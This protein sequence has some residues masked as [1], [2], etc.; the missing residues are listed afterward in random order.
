MKTSPYKA[1]LAERMKEV[2]ARTSLEE[3]VRVITIDLADLDDRLLFKIYVKEH[4]NPN[5]V[6]SVK[7]VSMTT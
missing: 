5:G 3:S 6:P 1:I 2:P 7:V 4:C